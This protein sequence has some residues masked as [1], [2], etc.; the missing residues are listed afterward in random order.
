MRPGIA[1][2]LRIAA[3]HWLTMVGT[4]A[5]ALALASLWLHLSPTLYRSTVTLFFSATSPGNTGD[6][7]QGNLLASDRVPS[8]AELATREVF[9]HQVIDTLHLR[10]DAE[11]LSHRVEATVHSDTVLLELRVADTD[12]ERARLLTQTMAEHI[13]ELVAQLEKP[14]PT[15]VS[16]IKATIIENASLPRSPY[17]PQPAR[18]LTLAAA[19]GIMLGFGIV[20]MRELLDKSV[21]TEEQVEQVAGVGVMARVPHDSRARRHP[22][23]TATAP[24]RGR[25]EAFR[26]LRTNLHFADLE[27][28]DGVY[29]VTGSARGEGTTTTAANLA[30]AMAEAGQK[31]LLL[32]A[33]LRLPAVAKLLALESP[34]GLATVLARD[35]PIEKA[36]QVYPPMPNLSVL[37]GGPVPPNPSELLASPKMTALLSAARATYDAVVVDTSPVLPVTDAALLAAQAD[38]TLMVLR[39]GKTPQE[40]LHRSMSRLDAVGGRCVGVV[41][42]MV[43]RRRLFGERSHQETVTWDAEAAARPASSPG[44]APV[45]E[46]PTSDATPDDP[47]ERASRPGAR[48]R[49]APDRRG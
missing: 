1:D 5:A 35:V 26:V 7:Y 21:K 15:D 27:H 41:L 9:A 33:D 39:Y 3:R 20:I 29:V 46:P 49:L 22:V 37:A 6:A 16:P 17:S 40:D 42:N 36:V 30:L 38:G 28:Q 23:V 25:V 12:P 13:T 18:A 2:Y 34:V 48:R 24:Q 43:P 8:Y 19:L 47:Q 10:M 14:G 44:T 45:A 32:D 11:A 31:V 4:T